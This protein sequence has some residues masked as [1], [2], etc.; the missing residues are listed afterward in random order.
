MTTASSGYR[1][2][3]FFAGLGAGV[4]V[5]IAMQ[6]V[7]RLLGAVSLAELVAYRIIALLPLWLFSLGVETLGGLAKQ[8][9]LGLVLVGQA[10]V[11]G[12]LGVTWATFAGGREPGA[13]ASRRSAPLWSPTAAGGARFGVLLFFAIEIA[14][15]PL[16]GGGLFGR[17]LLGGAVAVGLT[18][19]AEA[20]LYGLA[21]GLS[22]TWLRRTAPDTAGPVLTR[23]QLVRQGLLAV[24]A[25][26]VGG[27]ALGFFTRRGGGGASTAA[28][29]RRVGNGDLPP[30]VTPTADFYQVSKNFADP[31]LDA[32]SWKLEVGG[33]VERPFV[34]T[35]DDLKALPAVSEYRT[36]C[37][38]SNEVGG[39]LISNAG[40]RGVRLG[41]LLRRAGVRPG[42]VDLKLSAGD[43]YTE[44]FPIGIALATSPAVLAVYEMNGE[45]LNDKHGFPVRLLVPNI[46][47]MKNVKWV[48]KLEVIG[49]DY[50]GYWQERGW[51]D[52]ATVQTM[53]RIDFPRAGQTLPAGPLRAGGVAFAGAR[54]VNKVELSADSGRTWRET[55]LR[56]PTGPYAWVLWSSE[57][58]LAPGDHALVVRATDGGGKTQTQASAPPAPDGAT[59]W[60]R[61][62]VR[63]TA[64]V[65]PPAA[66]QVP[67][68]ATPRINRS[69][70]YVP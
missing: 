59:G 51:S 50:L 33:L 24:T 34:L 13:S 4:L 16:L 39:D 53:S 28:G 3:S 57:F 2:A 49:F 14:L 55:Q 20:L 5:S 31:K 6:L 18:I 41:D 63:I 17:E 25:F 46:Y 70:L 65:A 45:P 60:H 35:F 36:L 67:V 44:S 9:L 40:W 15:L 32:A 61:V 54:G 38:I 1:R 23:R 22:Y 62:P 8:L 58:D 47:G 26:A 64:G 12:A 69:G 19:G 52:V 43:G 7:A 27:A 66:A 48:T 68:T 56:Q 11:G 21:L 10:V 37:C 42:A 29:G 30:D